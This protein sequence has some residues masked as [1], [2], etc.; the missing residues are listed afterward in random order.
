MGRR[1]EACMKAGNLRKVRKDP[2]RTAAELLEA[3]KD[4][5][6]AVMSFKDETD[7]W[8][9]KQS[10]RAMQN[11]FRAL[12]RMK[13]YEAE[14]VDCLKYA[15]DELYVKDK[16][17]SPEILENFEVGR[18]IARGNDCLCVYDRNDVEEIL[19]S[20]KVLLEKAT[21]MAKKG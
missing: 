7:K 5:R 10:H 11:A 4:L 17:F 1:F 6:H 14:G 21:E 2:G 9:V 16:V 8:A 13:G 12:L 15:M 18:E 3:E 20:T 19:A